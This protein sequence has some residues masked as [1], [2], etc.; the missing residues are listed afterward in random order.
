[1][2]R[3]RLSTNFLDNP[4][5]YIH[6]SRYNF[7]GTVYYREKKEKH[8]QMFKEEILIHKFHG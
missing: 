8:V 4:R 6:K 1:M 5:V 3:M 7:R 2:T